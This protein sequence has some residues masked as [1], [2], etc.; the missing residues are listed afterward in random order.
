[1][2]LE[3]KDIQACKNIV[4]ASS[5]PPTY[6]K[7]EKEKASADLKAFLQNVAHF[8]IRRKSSSA[9]DPMDLLP[10]DSPEVVCPT[11]TDYMGEYI[12]LK[13]RLY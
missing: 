2:L 10:R 3:E 9:V 13:A 1:M 6:Q 12:S 7:E 4:E 8:Q 11:F 5:F